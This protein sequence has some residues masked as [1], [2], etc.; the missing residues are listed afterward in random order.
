MSTLRD[1]VGPEDKKVYVRRRLLV[2]AGLIALIVAVVLVIVKPGSSGGAAGAAEVTVPE[3][4]VVAEQQEAET[5]D[6]EAIPACADTQLQVTPVTDRD[7][8][9]AGE[10]PQLSL[11]IENVGES[12]C[13]ADLGT[14]GMSLQV[15]S[16]VDQVWR[17]TDCQQNPDHRAVIV[18][19]GKPL[20]TEAIAW[21]RTRS[22]PDSCEISRDP[23][24]AGGATYHLRVAVGGVEGEGT[25][26]FLLY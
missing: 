22:S 21:D 2:L 4:L 6:P 13:Q 17:S 23:V 5:A 19:P 18:Q 24:G 8:Y 1:P 9:A 25:A 26:P 15:T 14:A 11:Q 12:D 3:D 7:S 10:L 20:M 16:G